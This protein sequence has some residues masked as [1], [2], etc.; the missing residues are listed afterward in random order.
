[1]VA[2]GVEVA[3]DDVT[4]TG[5]AGGAAAGTVGA[6]DDGEAR[7][8]RCCSTSAVNTRPGPNSTN[9]AALAVAL[10]PLRGTE[11]GVGGNETVGVVA[12][13]GAREREMHR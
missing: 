5:A 2:P 3:P 7:A 8:L 12:V 10:E 4:A 11:E 6:D 9:A 13:W 1:M